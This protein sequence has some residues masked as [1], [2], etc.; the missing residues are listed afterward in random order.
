[1]RP[2]KA[3][4]RREFA[5][6]PEKHERHLLHFRFTTDKEKAAS[7]EEDIKLLAA[8]TT[9]AALKLFNVDN[10]VF[11]SIFDAIASDLG[12][13]ESPKDL[14]E[15]SSIIFNEIKRD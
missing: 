6:R 10:R 3:F 14:N 11:N 15:L 12:K 5:L 9:I 13:E 4:S 8:A 1:M 7:L 2:E